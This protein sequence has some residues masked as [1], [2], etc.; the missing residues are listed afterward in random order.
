M[1]K[2]AAISYYTLTAAFLGFAP[3]RLAEAFRGHSLVCPANGSSH[4]VDI[5]IGQE[6]G[7]SLSSEDRKML[8]RDPDRIIAPIG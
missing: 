2:S 5:Q 4:L 3:G 6:I 7:S 1:R 8:I